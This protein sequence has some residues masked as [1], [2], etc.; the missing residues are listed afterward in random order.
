MKATRV[1]GIARNAVI[2]RFV[3]A[4]EAEGWTFRAGERNGAGHVEIEVT[5]ASGV[6]VLW[7]IAYSASDH[8]SPLNAI[9]GLRRQ[10]RMR[11]GVA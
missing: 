11:G 1:R 3:E 4:R 8:R 7:R 10:L 9:A 5:D 2:R 6:R